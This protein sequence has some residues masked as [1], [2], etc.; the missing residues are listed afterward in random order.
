VKGVAQRCAVS[1]LNG[2]SGRNQRLLKGLRAACRDRH[3]PAQ[4]RMLA[5]S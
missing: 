2:A 1:L 3:V 5:G 4:K